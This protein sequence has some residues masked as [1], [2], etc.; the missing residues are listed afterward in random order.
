MKDESIID[1]TGMSEKI[2]PLKIR[3]ESTGRKCIE[4]EP[5]VSVSLTI[6]VKQKEWLESFGKGKKSEKTREIFKKAME[7]EK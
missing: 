3:K 5:V 2:P 1:V 7:S 4:S 6:S